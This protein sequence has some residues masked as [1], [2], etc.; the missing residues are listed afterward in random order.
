MLVGLDI[1][2]AGCW[3]ITSEYGV[4]RLTYVVRVEP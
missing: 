1:P 3:E 2:S 4:E